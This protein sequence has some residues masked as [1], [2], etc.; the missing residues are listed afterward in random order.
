MLCVYDDWKLES[1]WNLYTLSIPDTECDVLE[2]RRNEM[3]IQIGL[4]WN[5]IFFE[6]MNISLYGKYIRVY[7]V[8]NHLNS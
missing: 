4:D 5:L 3:E 8:Q 1:G 2:P 7:R 6:F